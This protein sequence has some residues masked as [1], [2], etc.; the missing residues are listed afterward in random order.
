MG[1]RFEVVDI[2]EKERAGTWVRDKTCETPTKLHILQVVLGSLQ[3]N[4]KNKT[5]PD[6]MSPFLTL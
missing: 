6:Q 1:L 4:A 5:I 2:K 3:T